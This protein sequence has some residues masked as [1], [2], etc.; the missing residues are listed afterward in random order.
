MGFS[1][2]C[3][4]RENIIRMD[5]LYICLS[6]RIKLYFPQEWLYISWIIRFNKIVLEWGAE[7][8]NELN[9]RGSSICDKYKYRG[10]ILKKDSLDDKGGRKERGE[11]NAVLKIPGAENSPRSLTVKCE[12][13]DALE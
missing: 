13:E 11:G 12:Q 1:R 6:T 5:L 4:L 3:T 10:R 7:R 2:S 8:G 9:A